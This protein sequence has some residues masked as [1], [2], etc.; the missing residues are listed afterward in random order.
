MNF[1]T[2]ILNKPYPNE[3]RSVRTNTLALLGGICVTLT[4]FIFQPFGLSQGSTLMILK[5]CCV[6]GFI[7]FCVAHLAGLIENTLLKDITEEENW[8]IKKEII[9]YN[10]FT[11]NWHYQ[12][13]GK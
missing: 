11:G 7:T 5:N 8:T 13:S 4:L 9:M 3:F 6:F 12:C 1:V 10:K 2:D